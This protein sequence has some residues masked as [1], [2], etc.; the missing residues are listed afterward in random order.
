[1]KRNYSFTTNEDSHTWIVLSSFTKPQ[2]AV[3]TAY[4]GVQQNELILCPPVGH[5]KARQRETT[6]LRVTSTLYSICLISREPCP[7]VQFGLNGRW[8]TACFPSPAK[9]Q[10]WL[11]VWVIS[12]MTKHHDPASWPREDGPTSGK[13]QEGTEQH[14]TWCFETG[15]TLDLS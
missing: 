5:R 12:T 10:P 6:A 1:M 13:K 2:G 15:D 9:S 4:V 11:V 8:W 14:L 3:R 7:W